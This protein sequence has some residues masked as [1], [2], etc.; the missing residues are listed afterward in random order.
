MDR[1]FEPVKDLVPLVEI[2]TTADKDMWDSL[3]D[4]FVSRKTKT[5]VSS[6]EFPFENI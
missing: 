6:S 5:R 1:E 2:N 4:E 3:T